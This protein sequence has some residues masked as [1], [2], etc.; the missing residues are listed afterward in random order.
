[1]TRTLFIIAGA[2]LVLCLACLAG[3]ATLGSRDLAANDW[4]WVVSDDGREDGNGD[5]RF[6]RGKVSPETTR[7]LAWGGGQSLTI[8]LPADVTYVQGPTAGVAVTGPKAAV[9]RVRFV[10]GRLT[11]EEEEHVERGYIRVRNGG[12]RVWNETEMLKITITA[13]NVNSFR[14]AGSGDVTIEGYDQPTLNLLLDG[15]G[16]VEVTGRA[17]S[18]DV[19]LNGYG[20]ADLQGLDVKDAKLDNAGEG[21]IRVGPTG[22]VTADVT[23]DGDVHLSRRPAKLERNIT[24]D[25]EITGA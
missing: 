7:T 4:T 15:S 24:G 5:I 10:D 3:A 19:R 6:E 14:L 13:P 21:D 9:D 20:D 23:S 2:S 1:M 16:D 18:L 22:E 12:I 8:D 11:L 17:A 25:G